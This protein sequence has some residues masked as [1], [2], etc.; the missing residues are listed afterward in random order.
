MALVQE[1]AVKLDQGFL[2]A[3][4]ALFTPAVDSQAERQK[5]KQDAETPPLSGEK[6]TEVITL[7]VFQSGLIETDLQ[8]LQAELME[9]S[10]S[11]T[12]GLNFFEYFHISPIKVRSTP[13]HQ[14]FCV[15]LNQFVSSPRR[16]LDSVHLESE[17][18]CPC[19]LT[20]CCRGLAPAPSLKTDRGLPHSDCLVFHPLGP[21]AFEFFT[22]NV[23]LCFL[24]FQGHTIIKLAV[25][26]QP[27]VIYRT[28][29]RIKPDKRIRAKSV[30]QADNNCFHCNCL[31]HTT[32]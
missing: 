2:G 30:S 18:A 9:A 17:L 10:L 1:M 8:G 12:S 32:H 19:P 15:A 22:F 29:R 26:F 27:D 3:T 31:Q 5:V 21:E 13:P 25:C 28:H 14:Q 16:A 7:F 23:V 11:G 24:H 4:L 6:L 20:P